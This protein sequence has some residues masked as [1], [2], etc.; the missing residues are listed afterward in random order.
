MVLFAKTGEFMK[1]KSRGGYNILLLSGTRPDVN[2][3][4]DAHI[5]P[6]PYGNSWHVEWERK[7]G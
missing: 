1:M 7:M 5:V 2:V 4:D 3:G 6:K